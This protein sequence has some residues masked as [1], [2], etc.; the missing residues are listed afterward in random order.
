MSIGW[1]I[2]T[3][4]FA[5]NMLKE[6]Q[7]LV[8]QGR[9]MA[10]ELQ[11]TREAL[12]QEELTALLAKVGWAPAD[13]A[14]DKKSAPWKI[15]LAVLKSRSTVTNCWLGE[16][17]NIGGLHEVCR[18]VSAWQRQPDRVLQKQLGLTTNHKA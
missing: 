15:A 13:L 5:R 11:Q 8:G 14:T 16:N 10:A 1:I 4:G 6:N 17:L 9:R 18:Q 3:P 12:W 2:G 7:E